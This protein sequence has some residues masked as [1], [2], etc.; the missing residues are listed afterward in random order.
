MCTLK[1]LALPA[2]QDISNMLKALENIT[3]DDLIQI[4]ELEHGKSSSERFYSSMR[5]KLLAMKD[6]PVLSLLEISDPQGEGLKLSR[7][8]AAAE[9][10]DNSKVSTAISC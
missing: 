3:E 10:K 7:L 1:F 4:G 8:I 9:Y 6:H 2:Q 5:E